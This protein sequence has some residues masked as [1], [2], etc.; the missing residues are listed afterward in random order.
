MDIDFNQ[1]WKWLFNNTAKYQM[2]RL[3]VLKL[4]T[5]HL[6]KESSAPRLGTVLQLKELVL[7]ISRIKDLGFE[8]DPILQRLELLSLNSCY[9]LIKLAPPSVSLTY[10]TYGNCEFK[11]T[12]LEILIVKEC[13]KIETFTES[14]ITTPRLQHILKTD[15]GEEDVRWQLEGDL[16]ATIQ[17]VFQYKVLVHSFKVAKDLV[18]LE[19]LEVQDCKELMEVVE[20]DN[21]NPRGTN[22]ELPL[23]CPCVRSLELRGLPK[24]KYFYYC[25]LQ[26]DIL[27]TYTLLELHTEDQV[28]IEKISARARDVSCL[29]LGDNLLLQEIWHGS[30]PIPDLCFCYLH[31]LIVDGCQFLSDVPLFNLLPL[32]SKLE[33]LEVQKCDSVRTIF[34]VKCTITLDRK[35]TTMGPASFP[36]PFP[37]KKLT[38]WEL[39]NLGNV[40]NEDPHRI[41]RIQLLQEVHLDKCKCLANPSRTNPELTFLC[42]TSLTLSDLLKYKY[43]GICRI[44]T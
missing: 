8:E 16:N 30:M 19:K 36:L 2:H 21:A 22:L 10:L 14:R 44:L 27:K 9:D 1:A 12:S 4:S 18:K 11:F 31:S 33:T 28:C 13:P 24:F 3:K 29:I 37:L 23:L 32:L 39:P 20:E 35:G 25:S 41:L 7:S 42:M 15:K 43:N 17:N 6:L 38:L 5:D 34:D 26:F 40:W